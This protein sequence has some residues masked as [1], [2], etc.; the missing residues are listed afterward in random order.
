MTQS[1]ASTFLK[2]S[3]LYSFNISPSDSYQYNCKPDKDSDRL[4]RFVR[5]YKK[6]LKE[7]SISSIEYY[8]QIEL[9]E[10]VHET[11]THQEP[12]LHMHGYIKFCDSESL[13]WFLMYGAYLLSRTA[14]YTIDTITDS[15][16][17]WDYCNKQ[18]F[19][20]L[21]VLSNLE[22]VDLKKWISPSPSG[23]NPPGTTLTGPIAGTVRKRG[24]RGAVAPLAP[25]ATE[26]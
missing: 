12:R 6:L 21:P 26:E 1:T 20:G 22:F 25:P 13:K 5:A 16:Q 2:P 11:A 10:P 15:E 9:S 7:F 8:L 14:R 3:V 24:A 18:S 4:G 19:L 23:S 17:W